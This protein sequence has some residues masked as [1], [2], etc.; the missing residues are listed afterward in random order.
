MRRLTRLS[1][2]VVGQGVAR[3][4]EPAGA[5]REARAVEPDAGAG[6]GGIQHLLRLGDDLGSDPV[7]GDHRQPDGSGLVHPTSVAAERMGPRP[8]GG[9]R[10]QNLTAD[11]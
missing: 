3:L 2:I 5:E 6:G 4:E 10:R 1:Q 9:V 7:T 11:F 8:T